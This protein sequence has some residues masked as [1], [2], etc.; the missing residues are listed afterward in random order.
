[1]PKRSSNAPFAGSSTNKIN[2]DIENVNPYQNE[3]TSWSWVIHAE[4]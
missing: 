3:L 2:V 1:M 4:K